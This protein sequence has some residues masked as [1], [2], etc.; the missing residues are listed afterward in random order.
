MSKSLGNVL[1]PFAVI[2]R[3]GADALRFYLLRDV[4]FGQDGSVST[5]AFEQRYESGVGQRLRQFGEPDPGD[6]GALSRGGGSCRRGPGGR[7]P[8]RRG[9]LCARSGGGRGLRRARRAGGRADRP[10][11]AVARARRDLAA[12]TA[13]E[14]LCRGTGAVAVGQ[15]PRAGGG[16]RP[17]ALDVDRGPAGLDRAAAPLPPGCTG[18]LLEA[19]GTPDLALAGAVLGA[20]AGGGTVAAIEPLFPKGET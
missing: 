20:G 2:D 8:G 3:F 14:S 1:D 4:S 16:S 18:R 13:A 9:R 5:A 17:S 15:G 19:L 11:G 6:G 12:R 10:G 7:G